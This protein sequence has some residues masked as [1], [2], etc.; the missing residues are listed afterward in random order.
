MNLL[1]HSADSLASLVR[2]RVRWPRPTDSVT[3]INCPT[4]RAVPA[5]SSEI[6]LFNRVGN[7]TGDGI[8]RDGDLVELL[9]LLR[10]RRVRVAS[11]SSESKN[12]AKELSL[13]CCPCGFPSVSHQRW[14]ARFKEVRGLDIERP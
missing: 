3:F 9:H 2:V 1:Q 14:R 8:G 4:S 6:G 12:R 5:P 7:R 11:F 10:C 13:G